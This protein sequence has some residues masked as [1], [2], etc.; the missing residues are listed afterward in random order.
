MQID[1]RDETRL[2]SRRDTPL[3]LGRKAD[4]GR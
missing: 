1:G 4:A 2:L 3:V